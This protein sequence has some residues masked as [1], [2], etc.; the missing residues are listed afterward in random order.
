[1]IREFFQPDTLI[2]ALQLRGDYEGASLLAG[3]TDLV[4]AMRDD[5]G[6]EGIMIDLS[7]VHALKGIEAAED[8]IRIGP[9]T[10]F[11][12]IEDSALLQE[13]AG[14]LR[15]AAKTVGSPQIRN[16]GTLGGNLCNASAA[17]DGFTPLLCLDAKVELQSLIA[18][19]T[20]TTRILALEDFIAG[21]KKTALKGNEIL[22]GI[23][24][25]R[26]PASSLSAFKKIGRRNA[27]AIARLSGSC[28]LKLENNVVK[29][30]RFALGASTS[31]PER[32]KAVEEYLMS[33]ELTAEALAETGKL[34]SEY[35]FSQTG[36]RSSSSYKLPVI[37]KF[38][39]SLISAALGGKNKI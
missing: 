36:A 2:K 21:S 23:L 16:R 35:V 38:T 27:L 5:R 15:E 31:V 4:V 34:A 24:I 13:A 37:E 33:R 39:V 32:I 12:E 6:P 26:L 17:G 3:G 7:K 25:Q 20:V 19:G 30:I 18:N 28:V 10:T 1:M 29:R 11:T 9:M 22:T 14:I 8:L